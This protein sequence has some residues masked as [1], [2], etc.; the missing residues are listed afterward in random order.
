MVRSI[1]SPDSASIFVHRMCHGPFE[2]FDRDFV[3][4]APPGSRHASHV[5]LTAAMRSSS[6]T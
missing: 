4:D 6:I 2:I 3:Q 5:R 1:V